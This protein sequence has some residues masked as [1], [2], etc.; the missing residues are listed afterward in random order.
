MKMNFLRF[1]DKDLGD[2]NFL[3]VPEGPEAEQKS[4]EKGIL[5]I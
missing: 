2:K 4:G 5:L 1:T 3:S